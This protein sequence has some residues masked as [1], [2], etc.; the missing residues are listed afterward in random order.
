MRRND[1]VFVLHYMA[2]QTSVLYD[3]H[4]VMK[5]MTYIASHSSRIASIAGQSFVT[6]EENTLA[7]KAAKTMK[8]KNVSSVLVT[9]K[10]QLRPVGIVTE[11]DM[12]HR[13][14]AAGKAL[15]MTKL[16]DLMSFPL[17][18]IDEDASIRDA[19]RLMKANDI[20]RLPVTRGRKV[21]GLVTPE[22]IINSIGISIDVIAES[23]V[24]Q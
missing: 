22:S 16:K 20:R 21:V 3:S 9:K 24:M 15:S 12:V 7:S 2:E 17:I 5:T 14:E 6:L 10:G 1:V 19:I 8:E 11:K 4:S 13:G 23:E 18:V